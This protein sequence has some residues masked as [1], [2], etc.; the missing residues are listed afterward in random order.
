MQ[1]SIIRKEINTEKQR[2]IYVHAHIQ[3]EKKKNKQKV[4][5]LIKPGR[6]VSPAGSGIQTVWPRLAFV[7]SLMFSAP[8]LPVR[9]L[10]QTDTHIN[11]I[12]INIKAVPRIHLIMHLCNTIFQGQEHFKNIYL[13]FTQVFSKS[14]KCLYL[15][16]H[17]LSPKGFFCLV[18]KTAFREEKVFLDCM[19]QATWEWQYVFLG[20]SLELLLD[21]QQSLLNLQAKSK[22]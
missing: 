9:L 7:V 10:Q 19:Q 18:I 1:T 11:K 22:I 8:P 14:S 21:S 3:R 16:S 4:T 5:W 15:L 2:H 17:L 12:K 6:A 20:D 13:Y